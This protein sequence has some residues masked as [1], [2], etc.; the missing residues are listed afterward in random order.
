MILTSICHHSGCLGLLVKAPQHE[1]YE[2]ELFASFL[3][4]RSSQNIKI[5][6]AS[7]SEENGTKK[8]IEM[9]V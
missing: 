7:K 8:P 2:L 5:V 1:S 3:G 6:D 4:H 9:E